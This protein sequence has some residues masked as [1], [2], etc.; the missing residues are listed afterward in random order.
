[1]RQILESHLI[2]KIKLQENVFNDLGLF[3]HINNQS[4]F[5]SLLADAVFNV[6]LVQEAIIALS[7]ALLVRQNL[8]VVRVARSVPFFCRYHELEILS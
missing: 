3:T 8:R 1:M 4:Y 2:K 6:S 5:A 7:E